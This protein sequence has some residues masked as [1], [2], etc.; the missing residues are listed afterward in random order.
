[1]NRR[2]VF[3]LAVSVALVV[4]LGFAVWHYD[5]RK[6]GYSF[7]ANH[8][9]TFP[10]ETAFPT[11]VSVDAGGNLYVV[12][13]KQNRVLRVSPSHHITVAAGNGSRGFSGDGGPASQASL[14]APVGIALDMA[15]NLFIADTDN[16]RV[17][18]VDAKTNIITT[19]AGNGY[20][21]VEG[22]IGKLA[23]SS[24]LYQP[25]SVALDKDDDLY[26]GGAL[27]APIRRVGIIT[28]TMVKIA[29]T[30]L[31]GDSSAPAHTGGPFWVALDDSGTLFYADP[32]RNAVSQFNA[33]EG[34][35]HIIAGSAVCGFA[36]DGGSANGALLCFPEAIA[37]NKDQLYIADTSNNRIRRVNL[38]TGIIETVAGNGQSGYSGDGGSAVQ[39]SLHG[40]M[41]ITVGSSGGIYIADT[42]NGCVRYVNPSTGTITT[43]V[44]AQDMEQ[45]Q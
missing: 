24:D 9:H 14:D 17:R 3:V 6:T 45:A 41:G 40:P 35:A 30:R 4:A 8:A 33:E 10:P 37:L 26:I 23:T 22:R 21:G 29:G 28:H 34:D 44:T 5:L 42:G 36:G 20:L 1:M 39:A 32:S 43:L 18:R 7:S 25:V 11:G 15:G 2:L 31:S 16:N 12:I 27:A 38:D 13:E 19:V